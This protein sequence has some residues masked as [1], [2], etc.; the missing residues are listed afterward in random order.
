MDKAKILIIDDDGM[1]RE[2][3]NSMLAEHFGHFQFASNGREGLDLLAE[4]ADVDLILL[5][6]EMPVMD[7]REMLDILKKS[8]Q[9]NLIPVIVVAGNREDAVRALGNGADDF[10][11]KPYDS[12]ELVLRVKNQ[13]QKRRNALLMLENSGF[14][15]T[16]FD[17]LSMGLVIVDPETRVIE[18]VNPATAAMF[19]ALRE[20]IE[21]N[22]CHQFLCP[23][24]RHACPVCDLG[25]PVDNAERVLVRRD[26][27]QLPIIKSVKHILVN[28][29]ERLLESFVD[30]SE[31][32]RVENRLRFSEERMQLLNERFDLATSAAGIGVWELDLRS[33]GIEWDTQMFRLYGIRPELFDGSYESWRSRIHPEDLEWVETALQQ[34]VSGLYELDTEFRAI[35]PD[36]NVCHIKINAT[37]VRDNSGVAIRMIGTNYD[38]TRRKQAEEK[39]TAFSEELEIKNIQLHTALVAAEAATT[40]KSEFLA[41]MS[42]EIRTPMN[43]VIGMTGLLLDTDL[44]TAQARYAGIIRSSGESLLALINDILDFSKIEARRMDLEEIT[45]DVRATLEETAEMLSPRTLDKGLELLCLSDLRLPKTLRGDPGRIRQVIVNLAGNAVKFTHSG[46][47]FI[48]AELE[49]QTD[50]EVV[51]RFSVKDS[52]IGIPPDRQDAIFSPFT[53]VDGSTTRKYGGTGLGLAICKQLTELMGGV[54]GVESREGEGST[55]WFTAVLKRSEEHREA[56]PSQEHF[57]DITGKNVLVVDDNATSR[58]LLITLLDGWGCDYNTAPDGETALA[59]LQ[60]GFVSGTPYDVAIIDYQMPNMDGVELGRRIRANPDIAHTIMVMLTSQGWRGDRQIMEQVGFDGYLTKPMRQDLMRD[61]LSLVLGRGQHLVEA[62]TPIVTRHVLAEITG[63]KKRVLLAEDNTVNQMVAVALLKK[64][65]LAVDVVADGSEAVKA[66]EQ[67]PYDLV[68]MDCQMPIMDGYEAT[69]VI[70]DPSSKVMNHA[71]PIVAMT[72]NAMQGDREKCLEAGMDDYTSKPVNLEAL[73]SAITA[74]MFSKTADFSWDAPERA[75][76]GS[77]VME[78][79]CLKELLKRFDGDRPFVDEIISMS[80]DDLP[81]RMAELLRCIGAAE[82]VS[83]KHEVHTIKGMAANV[84]A[85]RLKE[86]AGELEHDL[87]NAVPIHLDRLLAA[88]EAQVSELLAAMDQMLDQNP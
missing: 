21:G 37:V 74:L 61:C 16:L 43:G 80:R 41:T 13:I 82:Y 1:N 84:C 3:L 52:G 2:M 40:A 6:L 31:R 49:S 4:H 7:G 11:T 24:Q 15:Q 76:Q 56:E 33:Y 19:G 64:M 23:A 70:R 39:L 17:N 9:F 12:V 57:V 86:A 83:A 88:L 27:S 51:V 63:A 55:F 68:L 45:F 8:P 44:T 5:D 54:I 60:E 87:G 26:G 38:I 65:G 58:F 77:G 62:Q 79:L 10:L 72:A 71:V 34:A 29:R 20:E 22:V 73:Q 50:T 28:G 14:L 42:H 78:P 59:L 67:I 30:I 18:Q 46:E 47:I 66:L 36:G 85:G 53:Q 69:R 25:Q 32:K 81:R 75:E 48:R 35:W